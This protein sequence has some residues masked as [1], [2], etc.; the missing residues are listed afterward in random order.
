MSNSQADAMQATL[1]QIL[2]LVQQQQNASPAQASEASSILGE[3]VGEGDEPMQGVTPS[4][5]D[6]IEIVDKNLLESIERL[7]QLVQE[8]ERAYDTFFNDDDTC[9]SIIEDLGNILNEA[10]KQTKELSENAERICRSRRYGQLGQS[11]TRFAKVHGSNTITI[12]PKGES[13]LES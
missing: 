12:N 4:H 6:S 8:K 2:Q 9:A 11:I 5:A 1:A 10:K 7:G 13:V 3:I